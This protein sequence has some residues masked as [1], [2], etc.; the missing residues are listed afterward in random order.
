M[1][2]INK[3]ILIG[4]LGND[5][6]KRFMPNG[7]ATCRYSIATSETW[8]DKNGEK[9][10]HT[11]WHRIVMFGKIAEIACEY[12]K[13]GSAVYIEG[14]LRTQEWT[15][16]ENIKRY[17]TEIISDTMKMLGKRDKTEVKTS[18]STQQDSDMDDDI[19]F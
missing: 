10:E 8:K 5:P 13:K 19:P 9:Q 17:T 18:N 3:V 15:D 6:E 14:R 4:H 1:P 2:S 12:L 7:T 16:K 11:E